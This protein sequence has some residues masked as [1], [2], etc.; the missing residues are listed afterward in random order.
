MKKNYFSSHKLPKQ[1]STSFWSQGILGVNVCYD[2]VFARAPIGTKVE[3]YIVHNRH[4][5]P[6]L[7]ISDKLSND[8]GRESISIIDAS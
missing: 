2:V 1:Q 8:V 4:K 6:K 3:G 7:Q 5:N